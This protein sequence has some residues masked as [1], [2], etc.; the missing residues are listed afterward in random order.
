MT[1]WRKE[2]VEQFQRELDRDIKRLYIKAGCAIIE[3]II[4]IVVIYFILDAIF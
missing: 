4:G 3:L 2:T 1:P